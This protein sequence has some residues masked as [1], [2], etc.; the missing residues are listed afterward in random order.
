MQHGS[1]RVGGGSPRGWHSRL[2]PPLPGMAL[3]LSPA[4]CGYR[5]AQTPSHGKR[6]SAAPRSRAGGSTCV[7]RP[8]VAAGYEQAPW[9]LWRGPR[10]GGEGR[11][12]VRR[13]GCLGQG[14][15]LRS[16]RPSLARP[17]GDP[18]GG[19]HD[20]TDDPRSGRR[21]ALW[22]GRCRQGQGAWSSSRALMALATQREA[23]GTLWAGSAA[24]SASPPRSVSLCAPLTH[25]GSGLCL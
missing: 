12:L 22:P 8:G 14:G 18:G 6:P 3:S 25:A 11:V 24:G 4:R 9:G 20:A 23:A 7:P 21:K 17:A 10:E 19:A 16:G 5:C 1:P 2:M 15:S 13:W